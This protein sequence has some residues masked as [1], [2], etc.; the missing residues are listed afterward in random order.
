MYE[1][2]RTALAARLADKLPAKLLHDV[3]QELDMVASDYDVKR[4]C[5]DLIVAE[6]IPEIIKMYCAAL[7][8]ENKALGTI[9]GYRRKLVEFF[10][11]VRKPYN[12]V[13]TNDVRVFLYHV[14]QSRN[15]KKATVELYRVS[16]NAFYNWLVDEE[17]LERN[18]ARR[19]APID[20]PESER[21]P[22]TKVELEYLRMACKTLR[23]KALI[24]FLFSTGCRVSECAAVAMTDIDWSD[25]SV[26]IRHGKGDKFRIV[27]FNAESEVS[28]KAYLAGRKHESAALFACSRAPYGHMSKEALEAEVRH[29]RSRTGDKVKTPVSPHVLRHTFATTAIDNGMPVEQVQQL[30]GHANLDTT[31][32]YVKRNQEKIKASHQKYIS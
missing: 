23:E 9:D 13:T 31:M 12:N 10:D 15:L 3:L 4:K 2:F 6:G 26:R 28:L 11:F 1:K 25:R 18:P 5:T 16:I 7:A 24:D 30:L 14:Q 8:V 19:I 17:Y 20:V 32:I 21:E 27:Y 22:V 29:I